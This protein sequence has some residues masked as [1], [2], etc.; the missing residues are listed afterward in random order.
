M[1][2]EKLESIL[3]DVKNKSNKDLFDAEE[4]LFDEFEKTKALI[5]DLTKHI[6]IIQEFHR[7]IMEEIENRKKI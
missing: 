4:F 2:K 7:K 5:I 6:D 3:N 1:E